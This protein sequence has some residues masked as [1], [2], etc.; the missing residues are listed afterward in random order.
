LANNPN[1]VTGIFE[2]I[3][4]ESQHGMAQNERKQLIGTIKRVQR[5]GANNKGRTYKAIF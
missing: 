3:D 4:G 2:N 5:D 1:G